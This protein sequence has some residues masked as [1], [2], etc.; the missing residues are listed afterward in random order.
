MSSQQQN[1][2]H[3]P[4]KRAAKRRAI[5]E[6]QKRIGD[7]ALPRKGQTGKGARSQ[8]DH[9]SSAK[10][11]KKRREGQKQMDAKWRDRLEGEARS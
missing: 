11:I 7:E 4:Q 8:M 6:A 10:S 5:R 3:D 2:G 1:T 9:A